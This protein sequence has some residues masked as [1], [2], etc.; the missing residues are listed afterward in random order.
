VVLG[1]SPSISQR[2]QFVFAC[3][4]L[5]GLETVV[6]AGPVRKVSVEPATARGARAANEPRARQ[7]RTRRE[8]SG[9]NGALNGQMTNLTIGRPRGQPKS[10]S[11]N[12]S[13]PEPAPMSAPANGEVQQDSRERVEPPTRVPT[14]AQRSTKRRHRHVPTL[15]LLGL[16]E[17]LITTT[18]AHKGPGFTSLNAGAYLTHHKGRAVVV[19]PLGIDST[20]APLKAEP[21]TPNFSAKDHYWVQM[22]TVA[23]G[24]VLPLGLA[25]VWFVPGATRTDPPQLFTH[26]RLIP[27]TLRRRAIRV[28]GLVV[29][30]AA[31]LV[32]M[33]DWAG[34]GLSDE[35]I[36]AIGRQAMTV[37]QH[38]SDIIINGH[39]Q[40]TRNGRYRLRFLDVDPQYWYSDVHEKQVREAADVITDVWMP[41]WFSLE[42]PRLSRINAR[43]LAGTK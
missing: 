22:E 42:E 12:G 40:R 30:Y 38:W 36:V 18:S 41:L 27:G 23:H 1:A 32:S 4:L 3:F 6:E 43:I 13:H 29:E 33:T 25:S 24:G 8:A 35:N 15:T 9:G 5:A 14:G 16:A 7:Q 28:E 11:A 34:L 31:G 21:G 10:P 19:K 39:L 20:G 17:R 37:G 26:D 2:Y